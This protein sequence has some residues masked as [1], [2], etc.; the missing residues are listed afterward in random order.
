MCAEPQ[1][2]ESDRCSGNNIMKFASIANMMEY[3]CDCYRPHSIS[4]KTTVSVCFDFRFDF[5]NLVL[6][7][8]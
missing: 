2:S 3:E 1:P 8:V 6:F 7:M 5:M 4:D